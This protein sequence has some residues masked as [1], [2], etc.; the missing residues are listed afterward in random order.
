MIGRRPSGVLDVTS[1]SKDDAGMTLIELMIVVAIVAILAAIAYPSYQ[2]HTR[3]ARRTDAKIALTEMANLQEKFR[4]INL[5][6]AT[7]IG[8]LPYASTS[9]EGYYNLS[10]PTAATIFV[11][12]ADAISPGPQADDTGCTT[13]TLNSLGVQTP[14]DP[15]CWGR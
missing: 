2:D 5:V 1:S 9:P 13:M 12:Q 8:A 3:R 4:S 11:L 14:A 6:Y 7:N 10:I 15:D